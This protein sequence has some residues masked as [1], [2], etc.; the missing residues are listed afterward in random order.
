M[1]GVGRDKMLQQWRAMTVHKLN[2]TE[3][4]LTADAGSNGITHI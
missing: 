1:M 3:N 2:T 4:G